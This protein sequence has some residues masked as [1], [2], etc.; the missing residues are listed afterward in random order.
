MNAIF[1]RLITEFEPSLFYSGLP[2]L[3]ISL[4]YQT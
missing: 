3:T 4:A 2:I 1:L